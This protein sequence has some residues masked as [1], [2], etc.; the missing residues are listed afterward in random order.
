VTLNEEFGFMS[1]KHPIPVNDIND[2]LKENH[3]LQIHLLRLL[4][5]YEGLANGIDMGLYEETIVREARRG[6]M[7]RTHTAFKEF[8]EYHRIEINPM[9]FV[10]AH[11]DVS[12]K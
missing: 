6:S 9:A 12:R 3:A 1:Q 10:S 5:F 7:M 11:F 8:I 2:K 4:N